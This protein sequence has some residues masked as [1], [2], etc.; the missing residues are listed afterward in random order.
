MTN[1]D[2]RQAELRAWQEQRAK[3][4]ARLAELQTEQQQVRLDKPKDVDAAMAGLQ[5]IHDEIMNTSPLLATLEEKIAQAQAAI[6]EAEA[7]RRAQQLA[8][9]E[10]ERDA[11]LEAVQSAV[12]ALAQAIDRL[13]AANS[14]V[15]QLGGDRR[16]LRNYAA[17]CQQVKRARNAIEAAKRKRPPER[18]AEV[19]TRWTVGGYNINRPMFLKTTEVR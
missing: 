16:H 18:P 2:K 8:Q 9:A 11:A 14:D 7:E 6:A 17:L 12:L 13:D 15:L 10:P 4:R 1:L 3:L 19:V 5:R